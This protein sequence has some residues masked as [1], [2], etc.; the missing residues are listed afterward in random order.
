VKRRLA[1]AL[2][3]L[4]SATACTVG[5]PRCTNLPGGGRY[6]LQ[7][8]A[9]VRPFDTQQEVEIT[10]GERRETLI[11]E[12]EVDA[13]AMRFAA[14]TPFGN[15]V[16]QAAYDNQRTE[17]GAWP[18]QG[19]PA[20]LLLALL[21]LALWPADSARAGLGDSL[22]LDEAEG[23]R[24]LLFDGIPVVEVSYTGG[25][26]TGNLRIVLPATQVKI[27]IKTLDGSGTK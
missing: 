9:A 20:A 1:L 25:R 8:T 23:R 4:L 11:V 21:Q 3:A 15:T 12:L 17:T 19:P 16:M 18:D 13:G 24:R 6:C 5:D 26:P 14:L 10:L 2:L 22:V 27:N 7:P